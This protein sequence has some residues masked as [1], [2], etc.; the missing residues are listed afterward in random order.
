MCIFGKIERLLKHTEFVLTNS[1]TRSTNSL[2]R[3]IRI[4]SSHLKWETYLSQRCTDAPIGMEVLLKIK[5]YSNIFCYFF[6]TLQNNSLKLNFLIVQVYSFWFNWSNIIIYLLLKIIVKSIIFNFLLHYK[7][8]WTRVELS[9]G[10]S[11][12]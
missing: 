5:V 8:Q 2:F 12:K 1:R 11:L 10:S 7:N 4:L 3:G 6:S 9:D